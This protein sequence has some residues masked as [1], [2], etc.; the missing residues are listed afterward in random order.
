MEL[1]MLTSKHFSSVSPPPS[2]PLYSQGLLGPLIQSKRA[3]LYV[4]SQ[5]SQHLP[6]IKL[7]KKKKFNDGE[8]GLG[9]EEHRE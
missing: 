9:T 6:S 4:I 1:K 7:K 2:D 3:V 5:S 8:W